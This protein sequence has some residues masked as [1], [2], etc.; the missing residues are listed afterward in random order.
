MAPLKKIVAGKDLVVVALGT[1]D[2][3]PD[4]TITDAESR[5]NQMLDLVGSSTPVLWVN[6]YRDDTKNGE[7]A[8]ERFD[9]A[10]QMVAE[11]R[12]NVTVLDWSTYIQAHTDLMGADHIHLTAKGYD[13]RAAWLAD[14]I[15][16][17][18]RLPPEPPPA[19]LR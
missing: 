4:L 15:A 1:N 2:A 14:A 13:E 12:P 5:I 18:L 7:A 17:G 19:N 10:L 8:A 9:S 16:A 6:V 11:D 3:R